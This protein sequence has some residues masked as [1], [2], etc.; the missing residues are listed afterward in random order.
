MAERVD[1]LQNTAYDWVATRPEQFSAITGA[2]IAAL[3]A[4]TLGAPSAAALKASFAPGKSF[5]FRDNGGG[6]VHP[7]VT[8][9][10]AEGR[11]GLPILEVL[12]V[13][14]TGFVGRIGLPA[15]YEPE[16]R[17]GFLVLG[18]SVRQSEAIERHYA[19]RGGVAQPEKLRY[20]RCD[21]NTCYRDF[22][23]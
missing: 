22:V 20:A 6:Y 9:H 12:S 17:S 4:Q 23:R 14:D 16:K 18:K 7:L 5:A 3:W 8:Q 2:D 21:A 1:W 11:P 15:T 19:P 10:H 13:S